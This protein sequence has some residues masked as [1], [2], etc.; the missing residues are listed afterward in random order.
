MV[1]LNKLDFL[2]ENIK[3]NIFPIIEKNKK[4]INFFIKNNFSIKEIFIQD[5][6]SW[7]NQRYWI[8]EEKKFFKDLKNWKSE[9]VPVILFEK[10]NKKIEIIFHIDL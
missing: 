4:I 9:L 1:F 5:L 7:D 3:K 8:C 6:L 10:F 2:D